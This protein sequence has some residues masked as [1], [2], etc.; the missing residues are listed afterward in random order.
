MKINITKKQYWDLVRAVYM[1]YWMAN[2]ICAHDEDKDKDID[3]IRNYIFSLKDEMGIPDG[4]IEYDDRI[5]YHATLALDDE[6]TTRRLIERYDNDVF[7][8]QLVERLGARDFR[9]AYTDEQIEAMTQ[10]ERFQ[11]LMEEQIQWEE[12]IEAHGLERLVIET[13]GAAGGD[14]GVKGGLADFNREQ[15]GTKEERK[16]RIM[17]MFSER[18]EISNDDVEQA[19][20]VS[21]ATATRYLSELEEE[22]RIVQQGETGRHVTYRPAE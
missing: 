7:W 13:G 19:I 11:K 17:E 6:P 8:E 9:R 16:E 12:E 20:G 15:A 18:G 10:E 3:D 22:G 14:G 21:D 2:A 4:Y 1:A 5:G